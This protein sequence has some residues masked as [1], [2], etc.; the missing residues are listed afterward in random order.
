MTYLPRRTAQRLVV[1][2]FGSAFPAILVEL[3]VKYLEV[4]VYAEISELRRERRVEI[5]TLPKDS[6]F[7]DTFYGTAMA[8]RKRC[9]RIGIDT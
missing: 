8:M 4:S 3:C 6:V 1:S 7:S 5:K 2:Y 9:R